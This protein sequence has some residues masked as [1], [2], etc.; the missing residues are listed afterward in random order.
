MNNQHNT[1]AT[2]WEAKIGEYLTIK[3][4][5]GNKGDKDIILF[6]KNGKGSL[7]QSVDKDDFFNAWN[8]SRSSKFVPTTINNREQLRYTLQ[9]NVF[10]AVKRTSN[11]YRNEVYHDIPNVLLSIA[12]TEHYGEPYVNILMR[13]KRSRTRKTIDAKK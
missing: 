7:W 4:Q 13:R 12:E 8:N 9:H 2:L 3:I 11:A 10:D 6:V 1:F 5:Q